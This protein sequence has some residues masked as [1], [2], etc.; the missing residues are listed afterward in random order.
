[1]SIDSH[2]SDAELVMVISSALGGVKW[3][4]SGRSESK[5]PRL[6]N[7]K[8]HSVEKDFLPSKM[9]GRQ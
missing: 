7:Q 3:I 5:P 8:P 6:S 4:L 2:R 9:K 1:M